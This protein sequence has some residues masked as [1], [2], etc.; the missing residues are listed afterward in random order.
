[1]SA[2]AIEKHKP[3]DV[4]APQSETVALLNVIE[5]MVK[6]PS[7][8]VMKVE[9]LFDL[10]ERIITRN[11]EAAYNQALATM[12]PL[13]PE[14]EQKGMNDHTHK[15]YA[16]WEDIHEAIAAILSQHGFALTFR[17]AEANNKVTVTAILRHRDG[18]KDETSLSLPADIGA[19][20]NAVQA[21]GSSLSYGKRYTACAILNIRSRGED[22]DGKAATKKS[23][24]RVAG[25]VTANDVG[26]QVREDVAR[27]DEPG[28]EIADYSKDPE[29]DDL[30]QDMNSTCETRADV[31]VWWKKQKAMKQRKPHFAKAFH[32]QVV[33]PTW[34][35][36][37]EIPA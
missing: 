24:S 27:G 12:Q 36:L 7:V 10:Q 21:I 34:H 22:D 29:W 35:D 33:L 1:M 8:D 4:A 14:V 20:R 9:K 23:G 16:K 32:Q 17:T 5:R 3:Q 11:A 30:K 28:L 6:D 2:T 25:A 18:H 19:G 13:L 15:S 37:P 26:R 31:D